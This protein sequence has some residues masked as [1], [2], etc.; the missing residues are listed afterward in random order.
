MGRKS[1][2]ERNCAVLICPVNTGKTSFDSIHTHKNDRV[3]IAQRAVW[4]SVT[5]S[6]RERL[7]FFLFCCWQSYVISFPN[8]SDGHQEMRWICLES[9]FFFPSAFH[10]FRR[11]SPAHTMKTPAVFICCPIYRNL[12]IYIYA[13][14]SSTGGAKK[15]TEWARP[16]SEK[17]GNSH[18]RTWWKQ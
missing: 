5:V 1:N 7:S 14:L 3:C 4:L 8:D 17:Q 11:L 2:G 6:R 16:A 13:W 9:F 18:R 15:V 10:M 12:S